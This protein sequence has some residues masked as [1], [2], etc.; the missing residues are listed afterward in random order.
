MLRVIYIIVELE[1]RE[2]QSFVSFETKAV[3]IMKKYNGRL[4]MA[5]E[6][7]RQYSSSINA[8]EVHVLQFDSLLDF[9]NYRNDEELKGLVALRKKAIA[10][11][12]VLVQGIEKT[13]E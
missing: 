9:K 6:P 5:F 11:T 13:Y 7:D 10:N 2:P 3:S 12:T 4:V 8:N 1:I